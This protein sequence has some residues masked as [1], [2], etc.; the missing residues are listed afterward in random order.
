MHVFTC[1]TQEHGASTAW[2]LLEPIGAHEQLIRGHGAGLGA[3]SQATSS[4]YHSKAPLWRP[5]G[6][7]WTR[8]APCTQMAWRSGTPFVASGVMQGEG[9]AVPDGATRDELVAL[10]WGMYPQYSR[11]S[12]R[13]GARR[14]IYRYIV[15]LGRPCSQVTRSA[16]DKSSRSSCGVERHVL[17]QGREGSLAHRRR[18]ASTSLGSGKKTIWQKTVGRAD[19]DTRRGRYWPRGTLAGRGTGQSSMGGS[20]GRCDSE[21]AT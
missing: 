13:T 12:A 21:G 8:R 4:T 14:N 16:Y 15:A 3:L 5:E 10:R 17:A 6:D 9:L 1:A 18:P 2:Q 7:G 20:R 11:R 19:T